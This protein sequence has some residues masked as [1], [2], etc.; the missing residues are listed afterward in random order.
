[1]TDDRAPLEQGPSE[2]PT[3]MLQADV[4]RAL[5]RRPLPCG[6]RS[7]NRSDDRNHDVDP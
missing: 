2:F 6:S 1:M 5:E 3:L 7:W 4:M